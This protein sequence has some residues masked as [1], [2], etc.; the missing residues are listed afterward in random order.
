M[1]TSDAE[2]I[3]TLCSEGSWGTQTL[4]QLLTLHATQ[5]P[6]KLA[7]KDQPNRQELC[8]DPAKT[9]SWGELEAASDNLAG[10]LRAQG[11]GPDDKLIVQLPNSSGLS[12]LSACS[13]Y[14]AMRSVLR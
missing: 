14:R 2:R 8:G 4:H 12:G 5:Q 1:I 10:Q 7:L 9:L 11:I 3:A 13:N 6:D